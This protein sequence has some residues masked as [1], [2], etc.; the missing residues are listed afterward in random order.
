MAAKPS[1]AN[2]RRKFIDGTY[3]SS[4]ALAV[5]KA[6]DGKVH[7]FHET[8]ADAVLAAKEA[9]EQFKAKGDKTPPLCGIP[10]AMKSNILIKNKK[11]A[12]S[13]RI[14]ESYRA[15]Y[16]AIVTARLRRAGAVFV[17][18]TDMGEFA[19]GS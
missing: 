14:L 2:L 18:S 10:L 1:I 16:D 11:A 5:I 4:N 19:M 7:A 13:S 6:E 8:F 12:A 15:V 3:T 9:T 17:G